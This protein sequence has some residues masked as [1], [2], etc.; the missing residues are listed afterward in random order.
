M[1][2]TWT[3]I[4]CNKRQTLKKIEEKREAKGGGEVHA[5]FGCAKEDVGVQ[6]GEAR[7]S[8]NIERGG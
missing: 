8:M 2:G 6:S 4:F 1:Y 7:K 5:L 3:N